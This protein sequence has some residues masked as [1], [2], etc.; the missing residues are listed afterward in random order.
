MI[1]AV[2]SNDTRNSATFSLYGNYTVFAFSYFSAHMLLWFAALITFNTKAITWLKRLIIP[3]LGIGALSATPLVVAGVHS[4]AD[5]YAI[6]FGP[7]TAI[8][9]AALIGQLVFAVWLLRRGMRTSA[10]KSRSQ[11]KVVYTSLVIALPVLLVTQ[12]IAPAATGSFEVTDIGILVMALPV[13]GLYIGTVRHGLF[14]IK[15]AAVRTIAYTLSLFALACLYFASAYILSTL[16]FRESTTTAVSVGPLNIALALLLAFIFQPIK[17]FFDRATDKIFF[18]DRYTTDDF[19]ARINEVLAS[20]TD[21]RGLLQRVAA[22]IGGT[23]KADQAFFFVRYN[24][25]RYVSSGTSK[26]ALLGPSDVDM[27]DSYVRHHGEEIVVASLLQQDNT[28]VRQLLD[29][30]RI[31]IA[32]PLVHKSDIIGYLL[33]GEQRSGG[34]TNRDVRTLNNVTGELI[35]AIQNALSVQ[36]VKDL[37]TNLQQRVEAATR[38]LKA[39]NTRLR[40]LDATKDEFLSMAS[41][42]LRTPLTSVKGYISMVLEEDA[43]KITDMQKHLLSE[44]FAGSERM[45]HLIQDFLNVSRLQTGKFIL[46]KAPTNIVKLVRDE[47][48]SLRPMA[49]GRKMKLALHIAGDFPLLDVDAGK[50]R[51]VVMN[52]I[53]NALYYSKDTS[54]PITV[55][56]TRVDRAIELRVVDSGMGVPKEEQAHLFGKFFRATNAR[57]QRPDGTGVGLYLAKKVITAHGGD[58]IFLSEEGKG[59]TFGFRLPVE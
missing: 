37:N 7:L 40:H 16:I 10:N 29:R 36:E 49:E 56:L 52:Y 42:Q 43:G 6:D 2:V 5:V 21:L 27:L 20:T 24:H 38:E 3:L 19:Y 46:D 54:K 26:H 14:D 15:L 28:T 4:E 51:Q 47:V 45:V 33:L 34:Y 39:S 31:A 32:V 13:L 12:F 59:S 35:I 44:A 55:M 8:Y 22:E 17:N 25:T 58:I 11:I 48:A 41:H 23:L 53:D 30:H 1:A 9:G 18:R 50:L 57:K